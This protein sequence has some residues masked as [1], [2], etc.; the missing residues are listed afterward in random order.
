M[1]CGGEIISWESEPIPDQDCIFM[2]VHKTWHSNGDV[3]V[4]AFQNHNGGMST[5]WAEYSTPE[6]TQEQARD[7]SKNAVISLVVGE[8]RD[9]PGQSVEHTPDIERNNRAHTDVYGEKDEE[10]RI[11]LKRIANIEIPFE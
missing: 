1:A 9:I 8:V 2:R 3:S 7:P 4:G 5:N 10:V 11:K 6:Y